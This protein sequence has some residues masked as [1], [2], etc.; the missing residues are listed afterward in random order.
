MGVPAERVNDS[1]YAG[2]Q[3]KV[4]L[5]IGLTQEEIDSIISDMELASQQVY[6]WSGGALDLQMEYTVLPH[7][8]T[9]FVAPEFV[10]GP[11]D[12]DDEL[13]NA[14]VS[15]ETDFVYV[16]TGVYDRTQGTRL[17]YAC[18]GSYG[19]MSV[20]GASYANIQFNDLCHSVAI[21]G[22][23]V[24]EPLIYEWFHGL[25]WA[26]YNLNRSKDIYEGKGPDWANWKTGN[27][28]ACD[29]D[30]QNTYAYFP[31]V[32]LCEWDPDWRD[33]NNVAS[34]GI[35][36]HAGEVGERIRGMSMSSQRI[37]RL[38]FGMSA[39]PAG[40]GAWIS[41]RQGWIAVGRARKRICLLHS[42]ELC[43]KL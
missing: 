30:P 25:D 40:M 34:A 38:K 3:H 5:E 36:L 11:F 39:T 16:V 33:C 27:W 37:T 12:V 19:E 18:G 8:H 24:Y 15:P 32:D 21:A 9:G 29:T 41:A 2:F 28:P 22:E 20:H 13:L 4:C 7:T 6:A 17:A 10:F 42:K 23:Q 14:D 31:S 26:L 35:C 43:A 1:Q